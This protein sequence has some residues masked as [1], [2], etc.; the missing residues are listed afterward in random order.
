MSQSD[1][2]VVRVYAWVGSN[3]YFLG[4]A[5]RFLI[6]KLREHLPKLEVEPVR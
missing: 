1:S 6:D 3:R 5:P 4:T 2:D